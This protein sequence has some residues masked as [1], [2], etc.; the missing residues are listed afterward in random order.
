[1]DEADAAQDHI[2]R[3]NVDQIYKSRQP[4]GPTA[5]GLC[6]WCGDAVGDEHRWCPDTDC[7]ALW[8]REQVSVRRN[9]VKK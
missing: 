7:R 4:Q 5:N 8:E 2:E 1:M 9:G 6:H 3:E